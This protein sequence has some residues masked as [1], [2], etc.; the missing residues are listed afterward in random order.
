LESPRHTRGVVMKANKA[1]NR[2]AKIEAL[3]SDVMERYSA[4]TPRV[5]DVLQD[6]K[7]AVARAKEAVRLRASKK[8]APIKKGAKKPVAKKAVRAQTKATVKKVAV[9]VP[10]AKTAKESTPIKK[11][12]KKAAPKRATP[13]QTK[14]SIKKVA[15]RVP[16]AKTAKKSAPI[17]KAAKRAAAK[18]T[19]PVQTKASIK[20]VAVRVPIAKTAKKRAPIKTAARKTPAKKTAPVSGQVATEVATQELMPAETPSVPGSSEVPSNT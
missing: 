10:T 6:A 19:T 5:R 17:K 2:L 8:S 15:V 14:A 11:A 4:T 9:T 3:I 18:R 7:A 20:K 16:I 1:L 13:A 12:A